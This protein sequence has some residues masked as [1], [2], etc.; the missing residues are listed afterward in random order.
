MFGSA[1]RQTGTENRHYENIYIDI[2]KIFGLYIL[3]GVRR[4]LS[5]TVKTIIRPITNPYDWR[6]Y[7]RGKL[8]FKDSNTK[9]QNTVNFRIF[10]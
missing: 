4:S 7:F 6:V 9:H 2:V 5:E 1:G 10:V 3:P 8:H